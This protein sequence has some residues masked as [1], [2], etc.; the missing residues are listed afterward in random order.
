MRIVQK[1][2]HTSRFGPVGQDQSSR[3][4]NAR[5]LDYFVDSYPCEAEAVEKADLFLSIHDYVGRHAAFFAKKGLVEVLSDNHF[6][7]DPALLRS[8]HYLFTAL[9]QPGATDPKKALI[10]ARAFRSVE[11]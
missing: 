9:D 4:N 8:V 10:L 1:W 5:I 11:T 2:E 7:V 3:A 6:S